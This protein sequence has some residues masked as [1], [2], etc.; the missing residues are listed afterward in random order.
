[1]TNKYI[2]IVFLFAAVLLIPGG[3]FA[4]NDTLN[5]NDPEQYDN[6]DDY[7]YYRNNQL[8]PDTTGEI[9][10]QL[11]YMLETNNHTLEDAH[12]DVTNIM[13]EQNDSEIDIEDY[14]GVHLPI[15]MTY[16]D[17]DVLVVGLDPIMTHP[18]LIVEPSVL[19]DILNTDLPIEIIYLEFQSEAN[20]Q[21][22]QSWQDKYKR[23]CMPVKPAFV[24]ACPVYKNIMKIRNI[25]LPTST[26][27]PSNLNS[28]PNGHTTY[29]IDN[30]NVALSGSTIKL[31]WD[32][33]TSF[34]P[35]SY[36]IYTSDNNG[37]T[38]KSS[39]S[40]NKNSNSYTLSSIDEGKT[41]KFKLKMYYGLDYKS[42]SFYTNSIVIPQTGPVIDYTIYN[43][44]STKSG[45]NII[46]SWDEP[47]DFTPIKYKIRIHEGGDRIVNKILSDTISSYTFTN[48]E[49]G[50][51]YK[52][53]LYMYYQDGLRQNTKTY[54][55]DSIMV[56]RTTP[57]DNIPPVITTPPNKVVLVSG[58]TTIPSLTVTATDDTD[59]TVSVTCN[60]LLDSI[61]PMGKTTVTCTATDV[62]GNRTQSSFTVTVTYESPVIQSPTHVTPTV[63]SSQ[64][65]ITGS[66][67]GTPYAGNSCS[68]SD[69]P[70]PTTVL[71]GNNDLIGGSKIR[72][73]GSG[74]GFL[75]G[76]AG[77][78]GLV[79]EHNGVN[80]LLTA[81]HVVDF[82]PDFRMISLDDDPL[83]FIKPEIGSKVLAKSNVGT[84]TIT[85]SDAVLIYIDSDSIMPHLNKI[86]TSD[87]VL[88]VTTFGG[89]PDMSI[90]SKVQVS[91][92]HSDDTG[93]ITHHNVTVSFHTSDLFGGHYILTDQIAATYPSQ[94]GDSG[95]PIF[96]KYDNGTVTFLGTVVGGTC[97]I[98]VADI[99]L[100]KPIS[101]GMCAE[102]FSIFSSWENIARD[103]QIK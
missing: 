8:E 21:Q 37:V 24:N 84:N 22:T 59:G 56:P 55:P 26:F 97:E 19:Q 72:A 70:R 82:T 5:S 11:A 83:E 27:T 36:R 42:K 18:D 68:G 102:S 50:N 12:S 88:N 87:G 96:Q 71:T 9:D 3:A 98:N 40:I 64:C 45:D 101:N 54:S 52:F 57:V 34:T 69:E 20:I 39:I 66:G 32:K 30:L 90:G 103:L 29:A 10:E 28:L 74:L 23:D 73:Y 31:T 4:S 35:K 46:V 79:I 76:S 86:Q 38:Y 61:F 25:P 2:P 80:A 13:I 44:I 33:P 85:T 51:T 65:T 15:T 63:D 91:A 100:E 60:P 16:I 41:Y 14:D 6:Y 53:K 78:A 1:M 62:A 49:E 75:L 89:A 58:P 67:T 81:S 99:R 93:S 95:G 77:T 43:V 92:R 7:R 48:V 17:E 47:T 94:R